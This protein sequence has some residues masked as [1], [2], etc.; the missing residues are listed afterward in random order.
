MAIKCDKCGAASEVEQAFYRQRR[1]FSTKIRTLCPSCSMKQ[2]HRAF[3]RTLWEYLVIGLAGMGLVLLDRRSGLGWFLIN[4][5]V[6]E[7]FLVLA[8]IPHELGHGLAGRWMGMRVYDLIIGA[9]RTIFEKRFLGFRWQFKVLPF[10]GLAVGAHRTR[11]RLRLRQFVFVLAGPAVNFALA[12]AA[13]PWSSAHDPLT[14]FHWRNGLNPANHLLLANLICVIYSLWPHH[15]RTT[16]GALPSD[17]LLLWQTIRMKGAE[18][19]VFLPAFFA[20]EGIEHRRLKDYAAAQIWFENGLR[21][22]PQN[23]ALLTLAGINLIDLKRFEEAR[24]RCLQSLDL[25]GLDAGARFLT[26]N[27]VAYVDALIGGD[28]LLAEADEYSKQALENLP[29]LPPVIGTR[30]TVLVAL[31]QIEAGLELLRRSMEASDDPHGKALN[32]CHIAMAERK[33]G[34]TEASRRYFETARVLDPDCVLLE[35]A[36]MSQEIVAE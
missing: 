32:A 35:E 13:L 17:G 19:D 10:G 14:L 22:F 26:L 7:L 33:R 4:L 16:L 18:A 28:Q 24:S 27:N 15:V 5:F 3:S 36:A 20:L 12:A 34:D 25:P 30:G 21:E 1:S 8:A 9:G 29:W 31:G 6:L 23:L 11:D 2:R